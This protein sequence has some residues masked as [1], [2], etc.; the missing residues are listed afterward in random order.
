MPPTQTNAVNPNDPGVIALS[1]AI[2]Q[3][4]SGGDFNAV[5]DAGT[6]HGAGQWQPATWKAQAQDVLGDGNAQMTPQNQKAVIAGTIAQWKAQGLNPAEIAAKWNSGTSTNWENKIGTTNINGQQIKYNVPQYVKSVTDLYQQYKGQG[7]PQGTDNSLI[8]PP[9]PAQP[10]T[11]P[12]GSSSQTQDSSPTLGDQINNRLSQAGTAL[13]DAATGKINPISGILQTAGAAGGFV[14][15]VTNDALEL[16]PG[17]KQAEGLLGKGVGALANT[18]VGKSVVGAGENFAQAHPEL[19][20]DIGA[21]GNIAGAV[22]SFEGVGALK[23]VVGGAIGKAVGK[24]ALSS[25]IADISPEIKAGTVKG[26]A[27]VSKNGAVKSGILGNISRAE[28][29]VMREAA[30]VVVQNVPNFN[31]LPTFTDKLNA[32]Q[33]VAIPQEAQ[34]LRTALSAPDVQT[35]VNPDNYQEFLDKINTEIKDNPSLVGNNGET[36]ARFLRIFQKNLPQGQDATALDVL[37]ARQ[38]LDKEAL[39]FKPKVFDSAASN[40]YSEG[41]GTVR[42]AANELI[43][44]M[45]PDADVQASLRRQSLLY[46]AADNLSTKADKEVGTSGLLRFAKRHP[47]VAGVLK[48]AG[49]SAA[50]GLGLGEAQNLLGGSK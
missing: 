43:G 23:D 3:H 46:K 14:G 4:E 11:A 33:D 10:Y 45:A 29:P 12:Q 27:N 6:S 40:A 2:F 36:A 9:A 49:G 25:T 39:K 37:N 41:L 48:Y 30:P 32:I 19:A 50:A 17:V 38:A 22:G 8:A 7:A 26:A 34:K 44:K 1:K 24:D 18:G 35:I 31:K 21:V 15:D 5:G 16:I 13:G 42:N 28:D 47:H 20:G